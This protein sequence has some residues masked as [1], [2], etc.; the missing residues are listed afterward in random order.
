MM[1]DLPKAANINHLHLEMNSRVI[2]RDHRQDL[3]D[4]CSN[5]KTLHIDC[6]TITQR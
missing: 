6:G 5:V 3:L 1:V 2:D 4:I